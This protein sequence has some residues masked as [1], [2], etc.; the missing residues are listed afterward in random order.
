MEKKKY[1]FVI[2]LFVIIILVGTNF[3]NNNDIKATHG[4]VEFLGNTNSNNVI[5]VKED[6]KNKSITISSEKMVLEYKE[7]RNDKDIYINDKHEEYIFINDKLVG[8]LKN[9]NLNANDKISES[10]AKEKALA[11]GKENIKKFDRYELISLDYIPSYNEYSIKYM[12]KLNGVNTQDTVEINIDGIGEVVSFQAF[13]QGK[14]EKY[15]KYKIN[16]ENVNNLCTDAI[17]NKYG[18]EIKEI[19]E[20]EQYLRILEG[21]LVLQTNLLITLNNTES[22]QI[23]SNCKQESLVYQ[24]N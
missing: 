9:S 24:I 16:I 22:N 14:F 10:V 6:I 23:I 13:Q 17:K 3:L 15:K 7:T 8:F 21:K 19:E 1:V 4:T 5:T 18:D 2:I 20:Q 11:F 12:Y